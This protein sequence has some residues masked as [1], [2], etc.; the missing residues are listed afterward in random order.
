MSIQ[1]LN[2]DL[3]PY[4]LMEVQNILKKH[5]P[6]LE[7]WAFGS[8]VK[9]TAKS[10]SDLDLAILTKHP[11][12]IDKL[13]ELKEA[14]EESSLIVKVDLVDWAKTSETFRRII[15]EQKVVLQFSNANSE[16][17][18]KSY[19]ISEIG[20]VVT[21][22]TPKNT[23]S[24]PGDQFPFITPSD[25]NGQK[26]I[27]SPVRFLSRAAASTLKNCILPPE[28]VLVTCIG[29]DMGK[30]AINTQICITNQQI[31]AI[32][33]DQTKF[34]PE[35]IFYNLSIRKN[36]ISQMAGGSA[37]PILNK[38][39][40]SELW[41]SCP[42]IH[43]QKRIVDTLGS[44]DD[45]ITLLRETNATLEAIAQALFKSW[46]VDFDP[47]RAKSEGR[48]PEGMDEETAALFPDSFEES[49]LGMVP[50]GW[51]IGTLENCC[52]RVE[53]G[54]TP[55]RTTSEYWNGEIS[56]LTSGEVRQPI[57]FQT[58]EK[59]TELG[60]KESSAKIWET[61]TTIVAM[62]G[63]TAGEV[64]LLAQ[65]STANQACCG[66]M[67]RKNFRAFLFFCVRRESQNLASKSSGSA[68]QNL[69]KGLVAGH[70]VLIPSEQIMTI[71]EKVAGILL[72]GWIE[73]ERKAQTLTTLRDTLLP[74]LISGQLRVGEVEAALEGKEK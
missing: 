21:G 49:E 66:L 33:V 48:A 20:R 55:K 61:G 60:V 14:L 7:V 62:Y 9:W 3:N 45:R 39:A 29:S 68:Q 13:A 35:F 2:I 40:F 59:I 69:N 53:S 27:S 19:K 73:N 1:E 5:V 51:E 44:L 43:M 6:D 58:K 34:S 16:E 46:F 17:N 63:A 23:E 56:W 12:S 37:Q 18:W 31:N 24:T 36:E 57:I 42:P 74:R 28:S 10:Y 8:R 38:S 64:C 15:S 22:K 30:V 72:N 54:G 25:F 47:V 11:L 50:R 65:P 41:L 4:D 32:V 71:Y 26:W 67:P 52:S 70:Q